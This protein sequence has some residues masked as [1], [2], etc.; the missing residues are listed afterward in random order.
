MAIGSGG[1][2]SYEWTHPPW[3]NGLVRYDISGTG[4]FKGRKGSISTLHLP[5][6][7][8]PALPWD[9]AE[10]SPHQQE[11]PHQTCSLDLGSEM[12]IHF[13]YKLPSFRFSAMSST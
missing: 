13:L 7:D 2:H 12:K 5:A 1:L 11:V 8:C 10:S 9:F 3:V 4:G 6:M